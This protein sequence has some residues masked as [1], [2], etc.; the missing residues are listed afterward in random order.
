MTDVSRSPNAAVEPGPNW[1][2]RLTIGGIALVVLI[3][4]ILFARAFFPR[5]WAQRIGS[6]VDQS[7]AGGIW[8]G[9]FY[10]IIFTL[11]PIV[12]L[13]QAFRRRFDR[14]WKAGI[15][16]LAIILAI[17]NL[18]TLSI[19]LGEGNAAH[20]G[21]RIMDT[22]APAFRWATL[23]GA[24]I[25]ALGAALI[26]YLVSSRRR[27]GQDLDRVQRAEDDKKAIRQARERADRA[28]TKRDQPGPS[29]TS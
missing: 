24:I 27:R 23:I 6:Q 17:P 12:V 16:V 19:V 7:F 21:Q 13:R 29:T 1:K 22:E 15:V 8:W 14:R 10:G 28:E 20:A 9:L 25:G 11:V 3:V 2:R 26:Q 5:W 4:F 18:L